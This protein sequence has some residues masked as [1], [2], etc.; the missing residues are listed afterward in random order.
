MFHKIFQKREDSHEFKP[1]LVEIEQTPAAP[2]GRIMFWTI[3]FLMVFF[4]FWLWLGKVDVVVTGRG[5]LVPSGH[6][7]L[8]QPVS[9]GVISNILVREG[10]FVKKGQILIE[11]DPSTTLPELKFLEQKLEKLE[12]ESYRLIS[13][14]KK[15]KF[16]PYKKKLGQKLLETQKKMYRATVTAF[17]KQLEVKKYDLKKIKEQKAV[18]QIKKANVSE[19]LEIAKNKESRL[20]QVSDIVAIEEMEKAYLDRVAYEYKLQEL[21][22]NLQ[23]LIHQEKQVLAEM[24]YLKESF[25]VQILKEYSEKMSEDIQLRAKI[26][27]SAFMA[28]K[29]KILAPIDG[30]INE[31]F[32]H[33]VGG[34]VA[35]GQKLMTLVPND[36]PLIGKV[37]IHN[38][39][40]GFVKL[41]MP[42]SV[43][44]DTFN[45]QKYGIIDGKVKYI[46]SD[47]I[48]KENIGTVY[49]IDVQLEKTM[50]I[51][52]NEE[53]KLKP[54]LSLSAEINIGKRRIIE[55]FIYPL[56]K[57]LDEGMS[58]R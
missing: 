56:V 19:L 35:G 3:L 40:I 37:D 12:V 32:V 55:F 25:N 48:E 26:E 18:Q 13:I 58:V 33:T 5:K 57:Y 36:A 1:L 43:K 34:V 14:V 15:E 27:E 38:K 11:I 16:R 49:N 4:A 9:N 54:G 47:S 45:F 7:K 50:L 51:V 42:V 22:H 30:Y 10:A 29:Q 6:V 31:V 52:E 24:I 53:R 21:E 8:I 44:I 20:V 41:G 2:L 46:S 28:A 17:K 39:D 23:E